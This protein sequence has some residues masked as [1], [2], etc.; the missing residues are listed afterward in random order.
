MK[1]GCGIAPIAAYRARGINVALGTDGAASNN[2]LDLFGEMRLAALL[3]KVATGD[4][5]TLPA[6]DVLRAATLGGAQALGLDADV[7][8]L[9]AGKFAD[10]VAVDFSALEAVPC[11]DPV[12]HLVHVVGREAVTDVWVAGQRVVADR[13]LTTIDTAALAARARFW[14]ER[15]Q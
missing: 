7:G 8:S 10:I 11:Y 5:A 2:R 9:V 13:V 4:P 3:A 14:Q 1:L 12:S 15:L 6:A